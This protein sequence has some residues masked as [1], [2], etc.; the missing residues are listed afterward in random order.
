[1]YHTTVEKVQ[2]INRDGEVWLYQNFLSSTASQYSFN[3]LKNSLCWREEFIKLYGREVRVPRLT[4]WYGDNG[5]V[6]RY[7]GIS[8][9]PTPWTDELL[10]LKKEISRQLSV[11]FNGVLANLYRDHH[12]YMGWHADNEKS[13]GDEPIIASLSLGQARLFKLRHNHTGERVDCTLNAGSLLVMKGA[14]QKFWKH[15]LAKSTRPLGERINLTFRRII[16][17]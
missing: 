13:L 12:D 10:S 17:M 7:S 8:H 6:Y 3:T 2:L 16:T 15:S 4:C 1:M 14:L 11:D 5:A 9:H